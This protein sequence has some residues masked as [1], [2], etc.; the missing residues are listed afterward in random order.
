MGAC[1]G[2]RRNVSSKKEDSF[3]AIW[4]IFYAPFANSRDKKSH[5]LAAVLPKGR[6]AMD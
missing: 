4:E 1:H 5:K 2:M 3:P 6:A